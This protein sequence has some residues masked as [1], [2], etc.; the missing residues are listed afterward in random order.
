MR[1]GNRLIKSIRCT[2]AAPGS[3]ES[4]FVEWLR[5]H[6]HRV[7]QKDTFIQVMMGLGMSEG[8]CADSA[9]RCIVR[10]WLLDGKPFGQL[11]VTEMDRHVTWDVH[12][13]ACPPSEASPRNRLRRQ[14][15]RSNVDHERARFNEIYQ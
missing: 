4:Q 12:S 14:S 9:V 2:V 5:E 8:W 3:V 7:E 13:R 11:L 6:Q 1:R 10:A 15:R